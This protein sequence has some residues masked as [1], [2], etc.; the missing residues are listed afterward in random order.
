[1][2]P[3]VR[4]VRV[5]R[6]FLGSKKCPTSVQKAAGPRPVYIVDTSRD[7]R[8]FSRRMYGGPNVTLD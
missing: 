2:I 7:R 3:K 8:I 1:M 6:R 4:Y 5:Q